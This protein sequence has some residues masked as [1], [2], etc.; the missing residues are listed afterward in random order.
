MGLI[1][2]FFFFLGNHEECEEQENFIDF[3]TPPWNLIARIKE[4]H[5]RRES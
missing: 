5:K 4:N 1:Y 2:F 3:M